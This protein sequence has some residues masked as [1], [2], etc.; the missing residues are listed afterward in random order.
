[1]WDL[2]GGRPVHGETIFQTIQREVKEET[3]I[4][5][6]DVT[7]YDAQAFLVEY[8]EDSEVVSLHHTCLIYK[9]T[10][11]GHVR[12]PV[13]YTRRRCRWMCLA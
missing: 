9:A 12:I 10:Q 2:P 3:G 8:K 4:L 6:Q 5:I 13:N 7:F 1:M 11:F